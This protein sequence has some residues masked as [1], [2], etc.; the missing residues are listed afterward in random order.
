MGFV[1]AGATEP[2]WIYKGDDHQR[3][4][5]IARIWHGRTKI[6]DYEAYTEFMKRVAIPDYQKTE[7][8]V[9]LTFLRNIKEN[10]GHF[11]LITFWDNLKVIKNFAGEDFEKAKYYPEDENF[12]L[13][14]E[15]KVT[16]YEVFAE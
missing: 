16:H 10:V 4:D 15:E 5:M 1:R 3:I 14:F 6:E 2:M 11:T 12:L 13:E 7:G 9:K 8:F